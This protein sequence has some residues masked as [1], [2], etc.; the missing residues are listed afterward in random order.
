M[1][2]SCSISIQRICF[3]YPH[4]AG[5]K[6][7]CTTYPSKQLFSKKRHAYNLLHLQQSNHHLSDVSLLLTPFNPDIT[8]FYECK[9]HQMSN[10]H[11]SDVSLLLTS[12]NPDITSFCECKQHQISNHHL[13]NELLLSPS[14][15][16]FYPYIIHFCDC[17]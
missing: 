8:S 11:L 2:V 15:S 6:H 17:K 3:R 5:G 10:H 13:F 4:P 9:Q 7:V 16:L 14:T 1:L 12:F